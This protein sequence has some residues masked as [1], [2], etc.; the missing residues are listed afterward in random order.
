MP[1]FT[2]FWWFIVSHNS[3]NKMLLHIDR[4][5]LLFHSWT[6]IRFK[7]LFDSI[8]SS[9]ALPNCKSQ[10]TK[11]NER[12]KLWSNHSLAWTNNQLTNKTH[13]SDIFYVPAISLYRDRSILA[14][15]LISMSLGRR[16]F[17]ASS[18][19]QKLRYE[20]D[21]IGR[22]YNAQDHQHT[23]ALNAQFCYLKFFS[24]CALTKSSQ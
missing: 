14:C 12:I 9:T 2:L 22:A 17:D 16:H 19:V 7:F 8:S 10:N 24:D 15:S 18:S 21:P 11:T 5:I 23:R 13:P 20:S 3:H 4:L 6:V 1:I